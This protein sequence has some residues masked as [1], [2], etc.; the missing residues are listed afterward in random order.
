MK[1]ITF[2]IGGALLATSP[3]LAQSSTDNTWIRVGAFLPNVDTQVSI[4]RAGQEN[5]TTLIDLE[6]DLELSKREALPDL[7]IG[8]RL[9]RKWRIEGEV[10]TL[11]RKGQKSLS[12]DIVFDGVTY[13]VSATLDSKF[14]SQIYRLTVGYSILRNEKSELGAAIGAHLTNFS[15]ALK[16]TG[17]VGET[18]ASTQARRK[19]VLAPLPTVGLYGSTEIVPK[20][21]LS[22]QIDYLSLKIGDYD[23]RLVNLQAGAAYSVTRNL[24]LGMMYRRVD[25][26]L[27]INKEAYTGRVDYTF[28]GPMAFAE[29]S[30]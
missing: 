25:Y 22:G 10:F 20:L 24:R 28:D 8:T 9:G 12:R 11:Q 2:G 16:G 1:S 13:P 23:G 18:T 21:R 3:A 6:S 30:L 5:F 19:E 4:A 15:I 29:L 27:K 14:S 17:S 7:S 26:R